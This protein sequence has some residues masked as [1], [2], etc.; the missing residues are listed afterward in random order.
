MSPSK[1]ACSITADALRQDQFG[2]DHPTQNNP[3][4]R[5]TH[6]SRY[7]MLAPSRSLIFKHGA[8]IEQYSLL[9]TSAPTPLLLLGSQR[10]PA[11]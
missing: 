11:T 6:H 10:W 5:A 1:E 9:S 7:M 4:E 3:M 2:L 8:P